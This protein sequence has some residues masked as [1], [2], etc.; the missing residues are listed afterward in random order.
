MMANIDTALDAE[1]F[2]QWDMPERLDAHVEAGRVATTAGGGE[3]ERSMDGTDGGPSAA[4]NSI[5]QT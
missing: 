5:P 3:E 4:S 2:R 1:S